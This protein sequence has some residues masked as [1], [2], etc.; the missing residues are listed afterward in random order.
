MRRKLQTMDSVSISD[1]RCEVT[2]N[3]MVCMTCSWDLRCV[4]LMWWCDVVYAHEIWDV[5]GLLMWWCDVIYI[6]IYVCKIIWQVLYTMWCGD[7][8]MNDDA[9]PYR[10]TGPYC[11]MGKKT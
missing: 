11:F 2:Q 10:L 7:V 1:V 8:M 3:L 4:F 5:P 9:Y 6:Y